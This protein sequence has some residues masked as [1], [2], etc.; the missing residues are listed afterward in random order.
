MIKA[1]TVVF[2]TRSDPIHPHKYGTILAQ[3]IPGA[4]LVELTAKSISKERY[5]LE[6]QQYIGEFL[7]RLLH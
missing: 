5:T 2:V 1:P 4:E 6:T 7:Q 3:T